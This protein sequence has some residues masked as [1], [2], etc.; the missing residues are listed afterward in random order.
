VA[1]QTGARLMEHR[2]G[3]GHHLRQVREL[4]NPDGRK[5]NKDLESDRAGE[6]FTGARGAAG[7]RAM[8]HEH[9]AHDHVVIAFAKQIADTLSKERAAGS[10]GGLILVAEPHFLGLLR[11]ALDAPTARTVVGSVTKDLASV[12]ASDIAQHITSVLPL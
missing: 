12:N 3:Y 5:R 9:D 4:Q 1:H 11:D 7:R 2:P 6:S 10:Y 8:H